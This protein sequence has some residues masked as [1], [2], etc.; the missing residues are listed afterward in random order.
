M[1]MRSTDRRRGGRGL[2]LLLLAAVATPAAAQ[3]TPE[4]AWPE[5]WKARGDRGPAG[6][7]TLRFEAMTPGWH[8][9]TGP[10]AILWH[11]ETRASGSYRAEA[12]IF[13]F[14][15]DRMREA[16]G[17]F[18]G[19]RDL[20]G[21]GQAYTYFLIRPDGRY[22]V[23]RRAGERT[24]VLVDW[25][26]SPAVVGWEDR[27]GENAHNVLAIEVGPEEV[28]FF[29]NGEEVDRIP[30]GEPSLDGI[31]GLRVNHGLDLHV[32]RLD[33]EGEAEGGG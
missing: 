22:L 3:Q 33:V 5:G 18:V 21:E 32:A 28:A 10:A 11:P 6:P 9:T 15:P 19:G 31:V 4:G 13:L 1:R 25:T 17:L 14:E 12:E 20:E 29:A 8:V 2:A 7:A 23:K 26:A 24:E 27:E 30:R 16:F